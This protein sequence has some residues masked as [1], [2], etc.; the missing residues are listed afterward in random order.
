MTTTLANGVR[1]TKTLTLSP[2]GHL[3][4]LSYHFQNPTAQP[5]E[6][7]KWTWGWGPGL[8]TAVG[9]FKENARLIRA[10]TLGKLKVHVIKP[11]EIPEMGRWGGHGQP[12]VLGGL[13]QKR[14]FTLSRWPS[15]APKIKPLLEIGFETTPLAAQGSA[16]LDA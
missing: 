7:S 8:G 12:L 4:Q 5:I 15:R 11:P 10:I 13:Y 1:V 6:L 9:E 14:P 2:S 16:A 3:H